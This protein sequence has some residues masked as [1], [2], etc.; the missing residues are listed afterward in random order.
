MS[1]FNYEPP[2]SHTGWAV[3]G[4]LWVYFACAVPLTAFTLAVW[5]WGAKFVRFVRGQRGEMVAG[6]GVGVGVKGRK[7]KGQGLGV[8]RKESGV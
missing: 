8:E 2:P 1:F 4:A 3:S 6:V 5:F 7:G